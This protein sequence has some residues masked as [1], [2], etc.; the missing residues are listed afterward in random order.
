MYLY[1]NN[2]IASNV[3]AKTGLVLSFLGARSLKCSLPSFPT[4]SPSLS[5][6]THNQLI[7]FTIS[8]NILVKFAH[9]FTH[10]RIH[11]PASLQAL[12]GHQPCQHQPVKVVT[13]QEHLSLPSF[14][15]LPLA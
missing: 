11:Q 1:S 15:I 7:A 5:I 3:D 2:N 4:S 6:T 8:D 14:S 9:P 10:S 12:S 13:A